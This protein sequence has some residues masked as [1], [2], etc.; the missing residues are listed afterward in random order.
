[1]KQTRN[2]ERTRDQILQAAK[3]VFAEKG[4]DGAVVSEIAR[5]ASV[6][7]QLVHHHF[8]DKERL[9]REVHEL[10]F[11]PT[12]EWQEAFPGDPA[13]LIAD[14]FVKR[15]ANADYTRFLTWEAASGRKNLPARGVRKQRLD[16]TA[17]V[18]QRMQDEG[19]LAA[20]VDC[21]LVQLAIVALSTYPLAFKQNTLLVTGRSAT[22]AAFRRDWSEFLREIGR[23]LFQPEAAEQPLPTKRKSKK[24][25]EKDK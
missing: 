23:R 22:G 11:R 9:F 10:K 25:K 15:A 16:D 2:R 7:K 14:R 13:E 17:A 24:P 18:L 5:R 6:S 1:M 12:G 19:K 20:N 8:G 3:R 4:F 21:R